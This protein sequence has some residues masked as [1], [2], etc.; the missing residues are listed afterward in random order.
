MVAIERGPLVFQALANRA[1]PSQIG[2]PVLIVTD[3]RGQ[4]DQARRQ[5]R[6]LLG[7]SFPRDLKNDSL[8]ALQR[9]VGVAQRFNRP[10]VLDV[11]RQGAFRPMRR[12]GNQGHPPRAPALAQGL[13]IVRLSGGQFS[14]CQRQFMTNRERGMGGEN[15]TKGDPFN[16]R[17]E[18]FKI[19]VRGQARQD[20]PDGLLVGGRIGHT[21]VSAQTRG[22]I[23]KPF[24]GKARDQLREFLGAAAT[25]VEAGVDFQCEQLD[26]IGERINGE[27]LPQVVEQSSQGVT[28]GRRRTGGVGTRILRQARRGSI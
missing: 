13:A 5:T 14:Q 2:A 10:G 1:H 28:R 18:F 19:P 7:P 27:A 22:T 21:Q 9:V 8:D 3:P 17:A 23:G 25:P 15:H 20:V 4:A 16:Q 11:E 6:P 24:G 26:R 12:S